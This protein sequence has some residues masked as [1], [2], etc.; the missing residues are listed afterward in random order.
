[1][2]HIRSF[3]LCVICGQPS[4]IGS[5]DLCRSRFA[6]FVRTHPFAY[7]LC[8]SPFESLASACVNV[9]P[10]LTVSGVVLYDF[11]LVIPCDGACP[12]RPLVFPH[13]RVSIAS[14][15]C[16]ITNVG[17]TTNRLRPLSP[18]EYWIWLSSIGVCTM[19]RVNFCFVFKNF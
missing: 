19:K 6:L 11:Y 14:L 1:M 7:S 4:L 9:S 13:L 18:H 8:Q 3:R 12:V 10:R 17:N 15:R 2:S 16:S 5:N